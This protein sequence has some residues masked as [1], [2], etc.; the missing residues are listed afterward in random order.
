RQL[1]RR[2][3]G[4]GQRPVHRGWDRRVVVDGGRHGS[5]RPPRARTMVGPG[6]RRAA[7]VGLRPGGRMTK[8]YAVTI[9]QTPPAEYMAPWFRFMASE[10]RDI[11]VTVL[12]ASTP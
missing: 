11:D 2:A 3:A 10:R 1:Q 5:H 4:R 9:L 8:R 7:G 6:A 12:Y